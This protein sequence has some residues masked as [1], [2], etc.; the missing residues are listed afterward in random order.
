TG[1][2]TLSGDNLYKY[3]Q[4]NPILYHDKSGMDYELND[5]WINISIMTSVIENG[6][7]NFQIT[8][9]NANYQATLN[10]VIKASDEYAVF[11]GELKNAKE[12]SLSDPRTP[13]HRF[14]IHHIV[15]QGSS[16]GAP[17]QIILRN[18]RIN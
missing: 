5:N 11:C 8:K 18:H 13:L 7:R 9:P 12:K 2:I 16:K 10:D 1:D 4:N 14:N 6:G 3:C 15:P 17:A